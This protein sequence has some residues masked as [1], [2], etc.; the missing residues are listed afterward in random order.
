MD[1][2]AKAY[3]F[4][5]EKGINPFILTLMRVFDDVGLRHMRSGVK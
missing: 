4:R 2:E 1:L 5:K 3:R